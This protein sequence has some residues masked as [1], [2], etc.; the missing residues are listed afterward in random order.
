MAM[1]QQLRNH[2]DVASPLVRRHRV[3]RG[4]AAAMAVVLLLVSISVARALTAPGT[5][6]SAARLAEWARGH[7]LS[8]LV[9]RLERATYHAPK[10]GGTPPTSSPL[11]A[12]APAPAPMGLSSVQPIASPALPGEGAW[13]V[14]RTAGGHP[15]MQVAY[16]RPDAVHTSYT[17]AVAWMDTSRLRFALHPGTQEPGGGRWPLGTSISAAERPSLLAAFNSGFR[18]DAARGGFREGGRTAGRMRV[19]AASFVVLPDGRATVGQW[20]RDVGPGSPQPSVTAAR[21][22]LDLLVDSGRPVAGLDANQGGRWGRTLG[23]AL[24]VWRSGV[25][26]TRS[27]ALVYVAGDRLSAASLATLLQRAGSVRAMELDIN[28]EWT[29]FVTYAPSRTEKN[30]LPDMQ[31]SPKRYDTT[32]SRDFITVSLGAG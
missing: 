27:G 1:G 7:G 5:D 21:Q 10:V 12:P 24:Y 18:L 8:A 32:S 13:H 30:L 11:V 9:D 20:G 31:R 26:V 2:E 15:V 22:N 6:S 25:G 28:P 19:G 14:L 29:S 17:A 16:L 3:R 4:I 23:N